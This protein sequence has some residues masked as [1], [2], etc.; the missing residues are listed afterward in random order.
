MNKAEKVFKSFLSKRSKNLN[1]RQLTVS[2]NLIDFCSNDYLGLSGSIALQ[3]SAQQL[4]NSYSS[5]CNGASGSRLLS[6]NNFQIEELENKIAFFHGSQAALIFNSGYDANLGLL[7]SIARKD[8]SIFYDE[9]SHASIID[10]IRLSKASSYKFR[11]NNLDDLEQKLIL[12]TGIKYVVVESIY[13]MDGDKSLLAELASLCHKHEANL[14]VDEAHSVGLYGVNG[15]GMVS[16]FDLTEK[17]FARIVTF[18]KALGC[19]G[20]AVLGSGI[21]KSF[22]INTAR[23]FIYTTSLPPHS[24]ATISAAYDILPQMEKER[25]KLHHNILFFKNRITVL[26]I[27][28]FLYSDTAIQSLIISGNQQVKEFSKK[29]IKAGFDIRPILSPTIPKETERLRI[30]LHSFNTEEELNS[31]GDAI[32]LSMLETISN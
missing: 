14:I 30:C 10:G 24:V 4:L 8:D 25:K 17:V 19:H 22:L 3:Q 15:S 12:T 29:L 7:S 27:S 16:E 5:S 32:K 2:E 28:G 20:A 6:G 18:G 11:H 13:S 23:S 31:L 26:G 21:L 1:L 9:L